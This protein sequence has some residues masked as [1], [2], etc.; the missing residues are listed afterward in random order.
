M[1]DVKP[2]YINQSVFATL[3]ATMIIRD[4][5][6][7]MIVEGIQN[8]SIFTGSQPPLSPIQHNGIGPGQINK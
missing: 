8:A 3:Q 7:V 6:A 1:T 5:A 4:R 2:E